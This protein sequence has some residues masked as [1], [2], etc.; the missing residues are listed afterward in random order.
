MQTGKD[1]FVPC[2]SASEAEELA[3]RLFG[4][5]A[6]AREISSDRDQNFRLATADGAEMILKIANGREDL[7]SLACQNEVLAHL[8]A[9]ARDIPVPRV[10]APVG[11]GGMAMVESGDVRH[12]V[13][14][15]TCL[16]GENA[17]VRARTPTFR[18][19]VGRL[20]ARL[21]MAL[22]DFPWT[23][24]DQRLM[25][26]IKHAAAL[27]EDTGYID[28]PPHRALVEAAFDRFE[29]VAAPRL[30]AMPAQVIHNDLNGN[31]LLVDPAR[32]DSVSGIID[33]GDLVCSP[34]ICEVAIAAAHQTFG[35]ADPA[36][37]V[38]DVL[39]GYDEV[40]PL[41]DSEL[42]LLPVL[43]LT[44]LAV[45]MTIISKRRTT[46]PDDTHFDPG[47]EAS[48]WAT[49]ETLVNTDMNISGANLREARR[50]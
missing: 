30:G 27:R 39:A 36:A 24:G 45:R 8:A 32:P 37:A 38:A 12:A 28:H 15:L 6:A 41:A 4:I 22:A 31:N 1:P 14:L 35:E 16:P 19:N 23:A 29:R 3:R 34:R 7:S 43:V 21:D 49:I 18:R 20:A 25:W 17:S 47:V 50:P 9:A 42:D 40:S 33:F 26:D 5:V 11:G 44:R 2:F 48:V 13:R 46:R 10:L